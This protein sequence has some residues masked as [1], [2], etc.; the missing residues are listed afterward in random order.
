MTDNPDKK[1]PKSRPA[2]Q[3]VKRGEKKYLIRIFLG[4]DE[5]TGKRTWHKTFHGTQTDAQKWLT[6][7]LRRR[8]MGEP[9]EDTERSVSDWLDEW[10]KMKAKTVRPRTLEIYTKNIDRHVKPALGN[11]K[12][13]AVVAGDI[14]KLYSDLADKKM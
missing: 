13:S 7:A 3:I 2:G 4:R 1:K 8:D 12:L 6:M 10:L 9:I 14:Q 11:R 5:S